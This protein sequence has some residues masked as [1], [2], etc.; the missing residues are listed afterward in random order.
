MLIYTRK[1]ILDIKTLYNQNFSIIPVMIFWN[2]KI[3]KY[4]SVSSQVPRSSVSSIAIL[5]YEIYSSVYINFIYFWLICNWFILL[6]RCLAVLVLSCYTPH[7][8]RLHFLKIL[9]IWSHMFRTRVSYSN[10]Q[11]LSFLVTLV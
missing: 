4:S 5:V 1:F 7:Y 10:S 11:K 3:F 9:L 8:L 2:F 6:S